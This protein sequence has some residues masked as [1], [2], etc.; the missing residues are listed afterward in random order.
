MSLLAAKEWNKVFMQDGVKHRI[1]VRAQLKSLGQA[2]YFSITGKIDWQAK[3]NRWM[4]GSGGCIHD[5]ILQHFPHLQLLV[6]MHLSYEDGV[7]MH[8]YANAAYFAGCTKYQ[9]RDLT[10][11]AKH[12]RV[13]ESLAETLIEYVDQFYGEFDQIT[14]PEQAWEDTC[15]DHSLPEQWLEQAKVAKS[16]LNIVQAVS[17]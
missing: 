2:P 16:M 7:P 10:M 14:T 1:K 13:S 3:N 5:E 6:E 11:L 12:L 9:K 4:E 8:A 17:A 15:F